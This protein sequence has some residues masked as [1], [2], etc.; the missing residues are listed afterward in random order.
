V[1]V[2]DEDG[3]LVKLTSRP[4]IWD[5]T[6]IVHV[7]ARIPSSVAKRLE[8]GARVSLRVTASGAP[9]ADRVRSKKLTLGK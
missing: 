5:D 4:S 1:A 9:G 3:R 2:R 6:D 7:V 8:R